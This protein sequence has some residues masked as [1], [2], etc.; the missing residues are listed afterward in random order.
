M[1]LTISNINL[2]LICFRTKNIIMKF[3]SNYIMTVPLL[4]VILIC[5]VSFYY[6]YIMQM[7]RLLFIYFFF[8]F[9]IG[10]PTNQFVLNIHS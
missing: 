6:I 9:L 5:L 1:A 3:L 2:K 8:H 10:L 4:I 7:I